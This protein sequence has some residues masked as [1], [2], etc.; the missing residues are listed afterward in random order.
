MFPEFLKLFN[1][2]D[3]EDFTKTMDLIKD[4]WSYKTP[5]DYVKWSHLLTRL[6]PAIESWEETVKRAFENQTIRVEPAFKSIYV[7][8]SVKEEDAGLL[9]GETFRHFTP[10]ICVHAN[11][12]PAF[13]QTDLK[14]MDPPE[15]ALPL[16]LFLLPKNFKT[17]C[18]LPEHKF[19]DLDFQAVFIGPFPTGNC[20][21]VAYVSKTT[22]CYGVYDWKDPF[23]NQDKNA[24]ERD[25][26]LEKFAKNLILTFSYESKYLTEE[27]VKSTTRAKGFGAEDV[28]KSFQVRWLGKNYT[29]Q[30]Q[31]I[32]Y[33]DNKDICEDNR[34]VRSHWRRG[35][36]HTVCCGAKRKQRR[37]QWFK[38]VFVN[39]V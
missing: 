36:W 14:P 13:L 9:I 32:I 26:V 25:F 11:I 8:E 12:I 2:K 38:P 10:P 23:N 1:P 34:S 17:L 3:K 27:S 16:F 31:R 37:Q 29:Q 7:G 6:K 22:V 5:L 18:D 35:H 28:L 19:Y 15:Y 20:M 24:D 30:K 21:G 4:Y 39:P 33:S